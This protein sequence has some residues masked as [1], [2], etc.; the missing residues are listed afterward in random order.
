MT[1]AAE[2]RVIAIDGPAASGKTSTAAEVARRLGA[3][4]LD[5]GALYRGL[6]RV[7][8]DLA[9]R[10]PD[11]IIASAERRR[12]ELRVESEGGEIAPYLD[13][14]PAE[15]LI[16]SSQVNA[17]VS[18]IAAVGRL[19]E[20]VNARLRSA[21][22]P[23]R[24][25][26]L[27]GR[28]IGTDVF[29]GARLKIFL[30]ATPASRAERRVRQRGDSPTPELVE[31]ETTALRA[32][33]ALDSARAVAPLRKAPD[34]V[35]LDTTSLGFEEQVRRIVELARPLAR[36]PTPDPDPDRHNPLLK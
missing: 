34:A 30:T 28:D 6:T 20:W 7:A 16:R 24:L 29:P 33:D 5:S 35:V 23:G 27:D 14:S 2:T 17:V 9:S 11:T 1:R 12:L 3:F 4:H 26:V 13:G 22:A 31:R 36:A 32:R 21:A 18:E 10:D 15:P 8:L 19:R 25:V